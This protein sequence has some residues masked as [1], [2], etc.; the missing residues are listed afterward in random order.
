MFRELNDQLKKQIPTF[1]GDPIFELH[2]AQ[3]YGWL[4]AVWEM[5]RR[6]DEQSLQTPPGYSPAMSDTAAKAVVVALGT[7]DRRP[8]K[9]DG[10]AAPVISD[11]ILALLRSRDPQIGRLSPGPRLPL[12]VENAARA[13]LEQLFQPKSRRLVTTPWLQLMYAYLIENT[14]AFEIFAKVLQ[15]SLTDEPFGTLTDVSFRFLRITEDLFF[16]EGPASLVSSITS[17]L[18]PDIRGTRRNAYQRMF[19]IDLNHGANDGGAYPYVKAQVA[20]G[21]FVRTFQDLL[22]EL[23][24]GFINAHNTSG[25]RTTDEANIRE[26]LK[27]LRTMMTA[28]RLSNGSAGQSRANLAREE[29]VAVATMEWFELALRSDTPIVVDLKASGDLREERLRQLGDRVKLPAHGRSRSFFQLADTLPG[30]LREIEEG[31]WE[32]NTVRPTAQLYDETVANNVA[33]RTTEMVNHWS[34]ASGVELKAVPVAAGA[35]R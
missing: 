10:P 26:L 34:I 22:R 21:D 35:L 23:W 5:W 20:N 28:R 19:G 33:A 30:F 25:P 27:K 8:P 7:V 15:G 4:E 31:E 17:W 6:L 12:D 14:R 11:P 16:R 9:G 29:F 13:V 18:R 1:Q 3:L 2:P 24:R 32:D